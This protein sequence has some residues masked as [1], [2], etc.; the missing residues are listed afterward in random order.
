[1]KSQNKYHAKKAMCRC[2]HTHD[3]RKE[4]IRCNTLHLMQKSGKIS[5]LRMQVPYTLIPAQRIN[6]KV[7]ERA[8]KYIADFVYIRDGV[9]I[10]EDVKG[11]KAGQA[12]SLFVIKRKL[13]LYVHGIRV[14]EI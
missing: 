6:G 10:A 2:G 13:M 5:D 1:M 7:V 9:E 14:E 11:Y 8:C 3:S 4:A 12:Y